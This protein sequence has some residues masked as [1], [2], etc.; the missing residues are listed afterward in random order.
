MGKLDKYDEYFSELDSYQ[1]R[2]DDLVKVEG[3]LDLDSREPKDKEILLVR[4]KRG[5]QLKVIF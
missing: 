4:M 1:Q 5:E 2:V 3:A